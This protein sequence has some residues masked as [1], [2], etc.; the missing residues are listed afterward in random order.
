MLP[1]HFVQV[2]ELPLTPN[3]K[4][5]KKALPSPEGLGIST[6]VEYVAARN[7]VEE[8]LVGIW[9]EVLGKENVGVHDNFFELGGHSLKAIRILSAVHNIFNEKI[10]IDKIFIN[11]TIENL[12][13]EIKNAMWFQK[14]KDAPGVKKMTI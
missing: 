11:P 3:G 1:A 7:E 14:S 10:N 12:A 5:D 13:L 4:V 6:G 9:E 8:Q 2:K